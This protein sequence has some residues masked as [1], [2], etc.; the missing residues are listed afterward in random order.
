MIQEPTFTHDTHV[1]AAATN[2][3]LHSGSFFLQLLRVNIPFYM[4]LETCR[5]EYYFIVVNY[6]VGR[7]LFVKIIIWYFIVV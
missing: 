4:L 6:D 5:A 7:S 2:P 1:S 3:T